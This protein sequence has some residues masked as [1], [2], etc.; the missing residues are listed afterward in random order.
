MSFEVTEALS[1]SHFDPHSPLFNVHLRFS[2]FVS[3]QSA[4]VEC[5]SLFLS[6]IGWKLFRQVADDTLPYW[7]HTS[8]PRPS[9]LTYIPIQSPAENWTCGIGIT[10]AP[11]F[12]FFKVP[13][14][15]LQTPSSCQYLRCPTRGCRRFAGKLALFAWPHGLTAMHLSNHQQYYI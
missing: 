10:F 2:S 9:Q 13:Q 15:F 1:L 14:I 5:C 8:L 4:R 6:L 3:V 11:A 7:V 12:N